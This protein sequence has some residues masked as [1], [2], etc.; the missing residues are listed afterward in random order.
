MTNKVIYIQQFIKGS[1]YLPPENMY[2]NF[3]TYGF[4]GRLGR[5]FRKYNPTWTVEVWR[6]DS[7]VDKYMETDFEGVH[8]K[9]FPAGGSSKIGI[10][11][12]KF[13]MALRNLPKNTILNV[14]NIHDS[15][16]YQVLLFSPS[17]LIIAA[18]HHGDNHP[19]FK[20]KNSKGFKRIKAGIN[21]IIE[22]VLL[23]KVSYFFIIDVDHVYFL[24]RTVRNLPGKYSIQP[25]GIDFS[26]YRKIPRE[27]ACRELGLDP[28][29]KYLFY[30]GQYFNIKEVD[31][32]CEVYRKVKQEHPEVQMFVAGGGPSD[33][34]YNNIKECGAIDF[35]KIPNNELSRYYSAAD[36]YVCLTFRP[37][38]FGGIGLAM[39][40]A[41]ACGTPVVC[42]SLENIPEKIRQYVGKLPLDENEMIR[43]ILDVLR[44]R[45]SYSDCK[46][47][48]EGLYDY[49]VIQ[50]N[51]S[52]IYSKLLQNKNK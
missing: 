15:L 47:Y 10:Y 42:K 3:F 25:L 32:L 34:Y 12:Y 49:S 52:R 21:Y 29:K 8:F 11:S 30:L 41:M 14:Q 39:L 16:L 20:L 13:I 33:M 37:D 48:V 27:E 23:K 18:Q 43:D 28:G 2:P 26:M 1:G 4:G 9:I 22:K 50:E 24:A 31:R 6:L 35:G 19:Y 51:T 38:Y 44:N 36:V 17:H 40:E 7:S 46:K 45:E 5:I